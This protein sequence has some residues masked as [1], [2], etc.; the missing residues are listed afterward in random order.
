VEIPGP[1]VPFLAAHREAQNGGPN[2]LSLVFPSEE[3]TPLY[4]GHVRRRHFDPALKALG[5]TGIRP[6]DF[7]RTFIAL[8]VEAR[9]H[10]KLVQER[11][12]HSNI[13]LTMDVYGKLAGKMALG[14]EQAARL[15]A[16][17]S[18]ASLSLVNWTLQNSPKH[19]GSAR[20]T[21]GHKCLTNRDIP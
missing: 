3:G 11:V 10:P 16:M 18:V 21:K 15:D 2:P 13:K 19:P 12:G 1:L 17:A 20:R 7:R 8:H 4:P 6:H 5:L 14:A 9:T